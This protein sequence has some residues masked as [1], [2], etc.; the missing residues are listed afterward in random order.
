MMWLLFSSVC[1]AAFLS[2]LTD[3]RILI[4]AKLCGE[5]AGFWRQCTIAELNEHLSCTGLLKPDSSVILQGY[6]KGDRLSVLVLMEGPNRLQVAFTESKLRKTFFSQLTAEPSAQEM[7]DL[8]ASAYP[9]ELVARIPESQRLEADVDSQR[10]SISSGQGIEE[11]FMTQFM[12][13]ILPF[14]D[15]E[16]PVTIEVV[17][18]GLGGALA[19]KFAY[20]LN[21]CI[22]KKYGVTEVAV[23]VLTLGAAGCFAEADIFEVARICKAD[24]TIVNI[25][26]A[27]DLA[28]AL[29]EL[30]GLGI[31]G[32]VTSS[33]GVPVQE[34]T[35]LKEYLAGQAREE[36]SW[37]SAERRVGLE[38]LNPGIKGYIAAYSKGVPLLPRQ[39]LSVIGPRAVD[40]TPDYAGP[41]LV[42]GTLLLAVL[43]YFAYQRQRD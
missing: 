33:A 39:E 17:G 29:S 36:C 42:L 4:D 43:A 38:A 10:L 28:W 13:G 32:H 30:A 6:Q 11:A 23:N 2:Q 1:Q 20:Y 8:L 34:A 3:S 24:D 26:L 31:P 21:R 18:H 16:K 41:G 7:A 40:Q 27:N 14:L 12:V 25:R 5:M 9:F 15:K 22:T 19:V 35:S 37:Q